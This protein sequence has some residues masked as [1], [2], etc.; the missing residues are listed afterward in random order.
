MRPLIE[1]S[2]KLLRDV[3]DHGV[4]SIEKTMKIDKLV[5]KLEAVES[6]ELII[7]KIKG[8]IQKHGRDIEAVNSDTDKV[9]YSLLKQLGYDK[10]VVLLEEMPSW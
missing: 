8:I 1:Q 7:E 6:E 3:G 10:L 2:E 5:H 9:L 4:G